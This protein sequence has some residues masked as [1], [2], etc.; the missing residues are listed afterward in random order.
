MILSGTML[1][2]VLLQKSSPTSDDRFCIMFFSSFCE[3]KRNINMLNG[4]NY[5]LLQVSVWAFFAILSC[6]R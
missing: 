2:A 1:G 6:P 3:E 5:I 4:E